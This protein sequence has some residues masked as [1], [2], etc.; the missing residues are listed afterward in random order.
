M[1]ENKELRK[2]IANDVGD[3][4]KS[5]IIRNSETPVIRAK[6]LVMTLEDVQ[7]L[8]NIIIDRKEEEHD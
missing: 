2:E 3:F 4:L 5:I 1:T 6:I 7:G 8:F